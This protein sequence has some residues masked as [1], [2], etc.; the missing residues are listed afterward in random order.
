MRVGILPYAIGC[1]KKVSIS[2]SR[3]I[4]LVAYIGQITS[5]KSGCKE[6][7]QEGQDIRVGDWARK[8]VCRF[9]IAR[10][11][12][13]SIYRQNIEYWKRLHANITKGALLGGPHY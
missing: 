11:H 9:R 6:R 2:E 7:C 13:C 10:N 8:N 3:E 12:T 5:I 1:A 4:A